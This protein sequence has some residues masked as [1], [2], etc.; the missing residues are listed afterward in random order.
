MLMALNL[1][2]WSLKCTIAL[3]H[4]I[5]DAGISSYFFLRRHPLRHDHSG[6]IRG[7][8]SGHLITLEQ[9]AVISS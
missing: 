3:C 4:R 7:Q 2:N 1:I 5:S 8:Y 6:P 9:L